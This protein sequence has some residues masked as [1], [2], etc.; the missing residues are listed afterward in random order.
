MDQVDEIKQKIDIVDLIGS[1]LELKKA[2]AN[3]RASCPFHKEKTPS[4][5]VNPE[6][7]IFKC[8]GCQQ[9]GDIFSFVQEMEGIEFSDALQIL[10]EK[11]GIKLRQIDQ[12]FYQQKKDLYEINQL[13]AK[14]YQHILEKQKVGKKARAY[15]RKRAIK[16]KMIEQFQLGYAPQTWQTMSDFLK[17]KGISQ[18]DIIQVG[19]AISSNKDSSCY[20]RFRGRIV[21]PIF[22]P[23]DRVV[24]FSS[25]ILPEYDDKQMGKYINSPDTSIFDKSKVLY[26]YNF[27]RDSIRKTKAVILV[28]GQFDVITSHQAGFTN[29]VATSGTALT[30]GQLKIISRL[31]SKIIFAYDQDSAGQTAIKRGIDLALKENLEIKIALIPKPYQDVDEVVKADSK[32]WLKSLKNSKEIIDYYFSQT[33]PKN[34][35][36]LSANQKQKIG[37][38]LIKQ[39]AK[40]TDPIAQGDWIQKLSESLNIDQQYLYQTLEQLETDKNSEPATVDK[41]RLIS[42]ESRLLGLLLTFPKLYAKLKKEIKTRF[43]I[44]PVLKKV[45][46]QFAKEGLK[47]LSSEQKKIADGLILDVEGEYE[48]E[49]LEQAEEEI[50]EVARFLKQGQQEDIKQDYAKQIKQAETA[51][52]RKKVKELIEELQKVIIAK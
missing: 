28:E 9:S 30:E 47:S 35:E 51:G 42:R 19:L 46:Q 38:V 52:D 32:L 14:V 49:D 48:E 11:A 15:L 20:D 17:K 8:F 2:G 5:M 43:F 21:F 29:T 40:L 22:N 12:K 24:G 34:T 33:I 16:P 44:S 41:R 39:I 23:A 6:R 10:A 13:A 36:K 31:A 18:E 4:F 7:Q 37:K 50:K 27:A 1:Y 26:G 25:R 3:Y 45:Y